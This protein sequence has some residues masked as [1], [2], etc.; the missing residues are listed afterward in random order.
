MRNTS[1]KLL[2]LSRE[3]TAGAVEVLRADTKTVALPQFYM[4]FARNARI[5]R[6]WSRAL[7]RAI[8]RGTVIA[9]IRRGWSTALE[10]DI[11]RGTIGVG[12]AVVKR[13]SVLIIFTWVCWWQR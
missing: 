7:E 8:A 4:V 6:G 11:A 13:F 5:I 10:R 2:K 12:H 1:E 3:R 9:R